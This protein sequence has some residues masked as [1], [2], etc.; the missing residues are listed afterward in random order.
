VRG[1]ETAP[2][3]LATV[4]ALA[5]TIKK[6][7]V[8]SGVC[9]GFIGNRMLEPYL[10]E[11]E[12]L[13]LE[14]AT[15]TQ[16]D[17]AIESFGMAMGPCRMIDMAGIDVA[18]KV[19]LERRKEGTLPADPSYRMACQKLFELGRHGQKTGAGY[20]KYEGRTPV[21]DPEVNGIMAAL[22]KQFGIARRS[23]IGD[24]EIVERC[25]YP[26]INEGA[27]ILEEGIAYRAGDIDIVW[28]NGYGFPAV[29]GGPMH[30]ANDIGIEQIETCLDHYAEQ[31]GNAHGYWTPAEL[32]SDLAAAEGHFGEA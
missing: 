31:R 4:L 16:I 22:A 6:V 12:F 30:T 15:P 29:K 13:L 10:R 14:G 17:Q 7:A 32:L 2:A 19:V 5:K 20:Y 27:R 26:L 1:H 3:V 9:F 11:C 24:E 28:L 23:D 21:H 8:V 25:L 18:A